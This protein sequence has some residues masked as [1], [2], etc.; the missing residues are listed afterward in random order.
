LVNVS[1]ATSNATALVLAG[2][3]LTMNSGTAVTDALGTLTLTANSTID[4]GSGNSTL[5]FADS[6]SIGWTGTLS[7]W[8]WTSG[9]DYLIFGIDN[10]ALT[11]GQLN[12]ISFY[13]GSGG[14]TFLGTAAF[15]NLGELV[16]VPEPSTWVAMA[17]LT[18][19]GAGLLIRRRQIS[20]SQAQT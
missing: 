2:G 14:G 10:S 9:S 6:H 13:S 16:A 11:S 8:N 4:F 19:C 3:N 15:G 7:I 5:N 17:A 18:I 20:K 12:Q 1:S